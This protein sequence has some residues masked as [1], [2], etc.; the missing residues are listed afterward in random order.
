MVVVDVSPHG[1]VVGVGLVVPSFH[2]GSGQI[3]DLA[4]VLI[5]EL[6]ADD[7]F[8]LVEREPVV[9]SERER[10]RPSTSRILPQLLGDLDRIPE[11]DQWVVA[12]ED[13]DRLHLVWV[14]SGPELVL[15]VVH[16]EVLHSC[17]PDH[18]LHVLVFDLACHLYGFDVRGGLV[19]TLQVPAHDLDVLLVQL[20]GVWLPEPHL[21]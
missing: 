16:V 13:D 11:V 7:V 6:G 4:V 14:L 20:I 5:P 2:V 12:A 3:V 17:E 9:L 1:H 15:V 19:M 21:A 18:L 8:E 10:D